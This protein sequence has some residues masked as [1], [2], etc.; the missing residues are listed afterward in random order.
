LICRQIF[1]KKTNLLLKVF[2]LQS[3]VCG[4]ANSSIRQLSIFDIIEA[5]RLKTTFSEL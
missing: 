4:C 5:V 1:H 3:A 2:L